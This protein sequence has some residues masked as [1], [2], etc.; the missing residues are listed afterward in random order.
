MKRAIAGVVLGIIAWL[1]VATLGNFLIR[2]TLEGYTAVEASMAF[3]LPMLVA[4]LALGVIS[5]VCAGVVCAY[6]AKG[7]SRAPIVAGGLLVL[8]FLP[9]HA[10]LWEKF[11]AWYHLFF[12]VSL[13]PATWLGAWLVSRRKPATP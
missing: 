10:M 9:V 11:P 8:M 4:R 13:L 5:S 2:A 6:I 1:V 3:T 12:L 7:S